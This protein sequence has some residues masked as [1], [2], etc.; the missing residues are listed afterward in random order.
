[1]PQMMPLSWLLLFM[2][3]SFVFLL[4]SFMNY[5]SMIILPWKW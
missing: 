2:F 4:F 3:F 1:M 5:Y